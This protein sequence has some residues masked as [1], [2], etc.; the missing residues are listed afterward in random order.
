M[1]SCVRD[2]RSE[3]PRAA[4]VDTHGNCVRG[5][6]L[7][8]LLA[9]CVRA[10]CTRY[11]ADQGGSFAV[12]NGSLVQ[13]AP[14]DPASN[15][16]IN[17]PDPCTMLGDLSL[18]NVTISVATAFGRGGGSGSGGSGGGGSSSSRGGGGRSVTGHSRARRAAWSVDGDGG[19]RGGRS[20]GALGGDRGGG[21]GGG[22]SAMVLGDGLA[23]VQ[24]QPCLSNNALWQR[25]QQDDPE[26]GYY[27]NVQA[28]LCLN[29]VGGYSGAGRGRGRGLA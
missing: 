20:R 15:G 17:N 10:I 29:Q 18:V 21:G 7:V 2:F 1:R 26:A 12:S 5:T 14:R 16:W 4:T 27:Q 23:S 11:L 6:T 24:L 3:A 28:G 25:W 9:A 8:L 19:G 22:G 13:T